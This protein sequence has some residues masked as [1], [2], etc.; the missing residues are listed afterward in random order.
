MC[1]CKTDAVPLNRN[2][3]R[4]TYGHFFP[5]KDSVLN[6][7][8]LKVRHTD[9]GECARQAGIVALTVCLGTVRRKTLVLELKECGREGRRY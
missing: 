3:K 4:G 2:I 1:A 7:D 8:L 5:T 6:I 9:P